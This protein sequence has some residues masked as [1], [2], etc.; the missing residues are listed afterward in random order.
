MITFKQLL[1]SVTEE[2]SLKYANGGIIVSGGKLSR[3]ASAQAKLSNG[4]YHITVSDVP[5]AAQNTVDVLDMIV[6]K[7]AKSWNNVSYISLSAQGKKA[8]NIGKILTKAHGGEYSEL[9]AS[10]GRVL[11]TWY[12]EGSNEPLLEGGRLG[13][14]SA[15]YRNP[16][17]K[18]LSFPKAE[19]G[20]KLDYYI[21]TNNVANISGKLASEVGDEV[22]VKYGRNTST[23]MKVIAINGNQLKVKPINESY[24]EE[25]AMFK[26][27]LDDDFKSMGLQYLSAQSSGEVAGYWANPKGKGVLAQNL[28]RLLKSRG[29]KLTDSGSSGNDK[30]RLY[31]SP[32]STPYRDTSI[33]FTH[34]G[35]KVKLVHH[36]SHLDRT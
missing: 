29:W 31:S 34:D 7:L 9:S 22:N 5:G 18:K 24:L 10:R 8:Q 28:D 16:A 19:P 4:K 1:E 3:P 33:I 2:M 14:H 26:S 20:K 13:G 21:I 23:R 11:N 32:E 15:N 12:P 25:A 17:E 36:R 30:W 35:V 27:S 6:M